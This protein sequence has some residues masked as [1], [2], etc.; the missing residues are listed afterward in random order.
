MCR[1]QNAEWR[2][3]V[4]GGYK[5]LIVEDDPM[6]ALSLQKHLRSRGYETRCVQDFRNVME[7]FDMFEPQV[8]LLNI[9][10]PFRNGYQWCAEIRKVSQTPVLLTAA[11]SDKMNR[12]KAFQAGG[13][14]FIVKPFDMDVLTA[15]IQALLRRTYDLAERANFLEHKGALL[16][17]SDSTFVYEGH[18]VDLGRN[19]FLIIRAL[20]ENKGFVV[21]REALIAEL[22]ESDD[23]VDENTL[24]V[25]VTRLRRK[26]ESVGLFHFIRT[27][28]GVGYLIE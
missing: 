10:L 5:I 11:S 8:V 16:N 23:Y 3:G 7:E 4:S 19:D 18:R 2:Y 12:E 25:N 26:L 24:T 9:V 22:W 14:D 28:K 13:N 6:I 17:L 21:T 27:K 20:M 1:L 15:K